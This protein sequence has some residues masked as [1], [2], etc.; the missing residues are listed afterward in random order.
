MRNYIDAIYDRNAEQVIVWERDLDPNVPGRFTRKYPAPY[1]FYVKD[2]GGEFTSIYG[3]KLKLLN[4]N[5]RS[6]FEKAREQHKVKFESDLSPDEKILAK[7]YYEVDAPKLHYT[8]L[9]IEVDYDPNIGFS[10]PENPYAPINAITLFHQWKRE[11]VTYAVPPKSW[12]GKDWNALLDK[13]LPSNVT[14]FKTEEELL[15][16]TLESI[17]DSDVLSGWNSDFF[18]MPYLVRRCELVLAQRW[19]KR[20]CYPEAQPPR[21]DEVER[22]NEKRMT[23]KIFG[24]KHLD[25]L[26]LFKKFAFGGRSSYSLK[27]IAED[28]LKDMDKLEYQGSLDDLYNSDFNFFLRYNIRD[29]E[30]LDK[31]DE[32]FQYINLANELTHA[33][34]STLDS[35]MG[36]VRVIDAGII[37]YCHRTLGLKIND[38]DVTRIDEWHQGGSDFA[39][40]K[41]LNSKGFPQGIEGALVLSPRKGLHNWLGSVDINSLYP[42]TIRA[43][44]L[45]PE[46]IIGQFGSREE[47][48]FTLVL[49]DN[50]NDP[51]NYDSS[52]HGQTRENHFKGIAARDNLPHTLYFD[53]GSPEV[54]ATGAEW[55]EFLRMKK[56]VVSGYGTVFDQSSGQGIIP[57]ILTT[58]YA[59]RKV[60]QKE[61]VK[62]GN[63]ADEIA[64]AEG[65]SEAYYK[66]KAMEEFYDKKQMVKKLLLN[67]TYGALINK[68]DRFYDVRMGASTTGSGRQI[69][70]H[71]V[72]KIGELLNG[73]Y[74][75]T[76]KISG[77]DEAEEDDEE[78]KEIK[79]NDGED[80]FS[81]DPKD[82]KR[83]Y[84]KDV[85]AAK[86]A[87]FATVEEY[88]KAKAKGI[89]VDASGS[90][91]KF[92]GSGGQYGMW[93]YRNEADAIIYGDTDSCYFKTY[94]TNKEEAIA[95]ADEIGD[96][97][98]A[99]FPAFMRD[100]FGCTEGYDHLIMA[101]REVVADRGIFQAKKKYILRVVNLDGKD[102]A[103]D[104]KKALKVMGGEIKKSDTPKVIQEFLKK[105][106]L[107]ILDGLSEFEIGAFVN[108]ARRKLKVSDQVLAIGV[109]KS[110]NKLE[111]YQADY[112]AFE[113]AGIKKVRLP[114]HVRAA[115]NFNMHLDKV[116][117]KTNKPIKSGDKIK[118]FYL[119]SNDYGYDSF[120]LPGDIEEV[121]KWFREFDV[122]M[123]RTEGKLI[124]LKLESIFKPIGWE[125][126]T[127]Q[128]AKNKTLIEW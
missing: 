14:L 119:K 3:D 75:Q 55:Y 103:P 10:S 92:S 70:A 94:G 59:E 116:Q 127:I 50:R 36:S 98:N 49:P 58:W 21:F 34:T 23:V 65:K 124:D 69:T 111:M 12:E 77:D 80:Y 78:T 68:F 84:Q 93:I 113:D 86:K 82:A 108:D 107:K 99:S 79:A 67:S 25:F 32:K 101:G 6:E 1:Y 89:H 42:S 126:P 60:L 112:V 63:K 40:E 15:I 71:M 20:W 110:V 64:K 43:L 4:F 61:K 13:T 125:V 105:V 39:T 17:E 118:V 88:R 47:E 90:T 109:S 35:A 66:A 120:A 106:T 128:L 29:T 18:D 76:T 16:A 37:N 123:A 117:D 74:Y 97:V 8:L 91:V 102:I 45:S 95:I 81:L 122:D 31:L 52:L 44:N 26:Q 30:I 22:F 48:T 100:T 54:T 51:E 96:Q 33:N 83:Q 104:D 87:G 114:G 27:S 56:W 41:V 9:D 72:S 11:Y 85:R 24:R 115:I 53:D 7:Y 73:T 5:S 38:R 28:E 121:P 19:V 2:T 57:G 46:K 62:W